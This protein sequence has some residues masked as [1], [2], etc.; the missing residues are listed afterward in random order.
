MKDVLILLG[1][2]AVFVG[3][4]GGAVYLGTNVSDEV[5]NS[6]SDGGEQP[7]QVEVE[8]P[9]YAQSMPFIA[10]IEG[11]INSGE[12]SN[13]DLQGKVV[14]VDFWTYSCINC[15]RTLP[16]IQTWWERYEGDDFVILGVHAPEFAFEKDY[17]NVVT[18]TQEYGLTYPIALDNEMVTWGNFHNRY[19]PAK[20]LFDADGQLR[21]YHFGEGSY[22]E[23]EA[24]IVTLLGREGEQVELGNVDAPNRAMIKSP[25]TYFGWW[26]A[27]NFASPEGL[28][29]NEV[30]AYTSV[31]EL[32]LNE[33]AFE[34]EWEVTEKYSQ[35]QTAGA[36]FKF[37]FDASVANLV[38]ATEDGS[39]QDVVVRI[40]GEVVSLDMLG[41][42]I[43][44][45]ELTGGTFVNVEFSDLY[46]LFRGEGGGHVLEIEVL[47]PGLQIYAI[48]FG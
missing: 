8:L 24:A 28:V 44:V 36:R 45:D 19:W 6:L 32:V 41:G 16:Y 5:M 2:G 47:E 7:T 23:T 34:G 22:D 37:R 26:R 4:L 3:V 31:D 35:A 25:E 18:A 9:V 33:W 39:L 48:T 10:G 13:L 38:M 43:V 11:W 1:I 21:Y 12:L 17:D 46:E 29:R 14:L 42:D 15:I 30:I 20:Y 40:D 27:E